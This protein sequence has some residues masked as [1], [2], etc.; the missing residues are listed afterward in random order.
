MDQVVRGAPCGQ[1]A[2][3]ETHFY[4]DNGLWFCRSGHQQ[5]GRQRI[6]DDDDFGA[7]GRVLRQKRTPSERTSRGTRA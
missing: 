1:D 3:P 5:E 6:V 4:L 2:C 7:Q